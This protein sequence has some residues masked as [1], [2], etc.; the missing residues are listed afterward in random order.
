MDLPSTEVK[1]ESYWDRWARE[2]V[3]ATKFVKTSNVVV[4]K[5]L[6]KAQLAAK[7]A[8]AAMQAAAAAE[9]EALYVKM[10]SENTESE[11]DIDI[12]FTALENSDATKMFQGAW[13][14][15][16]ALQ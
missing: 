4:A 15:E 2:R 12:D 9:T 3:E 6:E 10:R 11:Y 16:W 1:T 13:F 14:E 5:S 8:V 7:E